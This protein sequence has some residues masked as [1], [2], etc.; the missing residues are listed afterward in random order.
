MRITDLPGR[1]LG[2]TV[3]KGSLFSMV[4][5]YAA[6]KF[7]SRT[8]K[9]WEDAREKRIDT[10]LDEISSYDIGK[11]AGKLIKGWLNFIYGDGQKLAPVVDYA[12]LPKGLLKQA[13]AQVKKITVPAS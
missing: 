11:G 1:I 8:R 6:S 9:K 7:L 10:L 5:S 4:G 13:Q 3:S 2:K 12:G